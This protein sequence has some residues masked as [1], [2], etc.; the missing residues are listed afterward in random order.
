MKSRTTTLNVD[1]P[2][3]FPAIEVSLLQTLFDLAPDV[4]FFIKDA[5]GQGVPDTYVSIE[6]ELS[7]GRGLDVPTDEQGHFEARD[8]PAGQ[9]TLRIWPGAAARTATLDR[10]L[11][12]RTVEHVAAGRQDL[13]ITLEEGVWLR[14]RVVESDG[15]EATDVFIEALGSDGKTVARTF[16]VGGAPFRLGVRRAELLTIVARPNGPPSRSPTD[17][18]ADPDPAHAARMSGVV[19]G[20]AEI[21]LRLPPR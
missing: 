10:Y 19:G 5:Q 13:E 7:D 15:S 17:R 14:G 18:L 6:P 4:A 3:A 9:Y 8:V 21:T 2:G 11:V 16:H 12:P 20:G 1:A